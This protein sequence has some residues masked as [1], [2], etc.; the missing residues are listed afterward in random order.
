LKGVKYS[1]GVQMKGKMD[2]TLSM[3]GKQEILRKVRPETLKVSQHFC[4]SEMG[5]TIV[6]KLFLNWVI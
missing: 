5:G 2:T 6:M 1:C 4:D 3:H